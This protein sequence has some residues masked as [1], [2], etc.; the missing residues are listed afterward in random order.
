MANDGM[1]LG[2]DPGT[3]RVFLTTGADFLCTVQLDTNWPVG[4]TLSLVFDD[5]T[6]WNATISGTDAVFS[7]DK[8]IADTIA[9]NGGDVGV[10]LKYVNGTTDQT[11][12][13]GTVIRRG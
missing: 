12:A 9:A 13:I 3:L 5:G 4:T 10:R 8:A 2:L 6:T 11:W 1:Q 7:V